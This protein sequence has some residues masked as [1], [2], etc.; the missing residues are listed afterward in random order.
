MW[1][2]DWK[3]TSGSHLIEN[4]FKC[5]HIF[6]WRTGQVLSLNSDPVLRVLCIIYWF[7]LFFFS[8]GTA[9]LLLLLL[10]FSH[11]VALSMWW[12]HLIINYLII[13]TDFNKWKIIII[14]L[15]KPDVKPGCCS[16]YE[17][18]LIWEP[19]EFFK[20]KN[21]IT[22]P[23]LTSPTKSYIRVSIRFS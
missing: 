21:L 23:V 3:L 11:G 14:R 16:I 17:N 12:S 22:W 10:L 7:L 9:T 6:V 19:G 1:E 15:W 2:P 20:N 13:K 5:K 18:Q 8:L 4:W